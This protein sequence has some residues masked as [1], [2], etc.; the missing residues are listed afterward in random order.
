MKNYLGHLIV[1]VRQKRTWLIELLSALSTGW[2]MNRKIQVVF[3]ATG[4][5]MATL[6][7][8]TIASLV[9]I[10]WSVGHVTDLAQ[11]NQVLLR[12]QTRS[13]AAQSLLKD[14][15]IHPDERTA[16]QLIDTLNASLDSLDA[17]G[18]AAETLGQGQALE[19]VRSALKSTRRSADRIIAAQRTISAQVDKEL[20][21][22]GPLIAEKL[23]EITEQAHQNDNNA[24][25]YA[26]GVA[27]ARYLEMRVNITRY[28]VAPTPATAR[29]IHDNQLDLEDAMNVAF[30]KL[31]GSPLLAI[32]D[33]AITEGVAYDKAFD[34]VVAA[35]AVRN[36]EVAQALNVSGP[37]LALSAERIITAIERVQGSTTFSAQ[38]AAYGAL[39]IV[40]IASA[41]GI[42]IALLAGTLTQRLI[43]QPIARMAEIMG[44]LAAGDLTVEMAG[45]D[46]SD[47]VGD[48]ARAVEIFRSNAQEVEER[49]T[50][51]LNA[52]REE[53][54]QQ[55]IRSREREA[56]RKRAEGERRAA[57][58]SLAAGFEA[59]VRDVVERVGA[60]A[61]KIEIEAKRVSQTVDDSGCL[62]AE[63]AL[64][65]TQA[66]Q[67]SLIVA[68]AT[69]KM[70]ASIAEVTRQM[71][72]A[73]D[74][75]QRASD[76]ASATDAIVGD[77]I[78]DTQSIED[79]VALIAKVARQTNL[80]ALNASIEA[81]RAGSAGRGFAVVAAEIKHL[82][83]QAADATKDVASKISRA[84]GTSSLAA[85]ALTEIA[86][87]LAEINGIAANV[88]NGM[89]QQ[90]TTTGQIV[91]ST[92]EAANG[93]QN[94]AHIVAQ[95]NEGIGATG[96]A[97]QQTLNAAA[98]LNCQAETLRVSVN[99]FLAT[100]RAA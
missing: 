21:V 87:T 28:L 77:L 74:I 62:A 58:L 69:E 65:T 30:E 80:L 82:A 84:R 99:E 85:N 42:I 6:A 49:R 91:E 59:S 97:A 4:A 78:A 11:A 52:G 29:Q 96:R 64:V 2:R 24:A 67:N 70:S 15:V 41:A 83:N 86:Y 25:S 95:V 47:E 44:G 51:A 76:S 23:R 14:Y 26:T 98:D 40:T 32:A 7:L 43:T 63:V 39:T 18:S 17:A 93:S 3:G 71:E 54:A 36:R 46:R 88:A 38:A 13:I 9:A 10:H 61:Q 1:K 75:A 27:Q 37:K 89:A 90:S 55:Q 5:A 16:A 100:V 79:I 50:A 31:A 92:N 72:S 34:Q 68:N 53:I 8:I 48:M 60:L 45:L 66:S 19:N 81:A 73:A 20:D 35:T 57:M 94:V 56:E 22:R 33:K 12:V